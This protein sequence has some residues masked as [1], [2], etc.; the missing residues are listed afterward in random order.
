MAAPH[1]HPDAIEL[2]NGQSHAPDPRYHHGWQQTTAY[3]GAGGFYN[4]GYVV[5]PV[6]EYPPDAAGTMN[7]D[8]GQQLNHHPPNLKE[9][10]Q[11]VQEGPYPPY[12]Q[13]PISYRTKS[14]GK[15]WGAEIVGTLFSMLCV[16]AMVIILSKIDGRLLSSW[17]IAVSPNAV[18]SVLST[19]SKAAMI[20]PVAE[21]LSQLK[22]LY[23]E[24]Q[25]LRYVV[26]TDLWAWTKANRWNTKS[27]APADI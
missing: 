11:L 15:S 25:G 9:H 24:R 7:N 26:C 2:L 13:P 23:L 4:E 3:N 8:S 14:W 1:Q 21:S 12:Q 16:V 22:W 5:S 6:S 20:L 27:R 19:A 17:T 18:I 10:L